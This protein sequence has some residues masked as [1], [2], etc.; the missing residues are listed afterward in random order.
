MLQLGD[1]VKVRAGDVDTLYDWLGV[2]VGMVPAQDGSTLY[3]C[4]LWRVAW[5]KQ[6]KNA[7][8][9]LPTLVRLPHQHFRRGDLTLALDAGD[10]GIGR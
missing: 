9:S 2:V 10:W 3:A 5:H 6:A 8:T 1:V 4:D 7:K